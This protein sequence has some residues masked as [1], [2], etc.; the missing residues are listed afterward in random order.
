[1]MNVTTSAKWI[2]GLWRRRVWFMIAASLSIAITIAFTAALGS[3]V[4]SSR[5]SLTQRATQTIAVDWQVQVTPQGSRAQVAQALT[6]IH[7]IQHVVPV[8]YAKVDGLS[9]SKTGSIRTTGTAIVVGLPSSYTI[10]FPQ[11]F[12]Y[13]VRVSSSQQD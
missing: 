11:Q 2:V 7:G 10:A 6:G 1:M 5:A 4:S 12:R 13:L 3:F 9:A 8:S